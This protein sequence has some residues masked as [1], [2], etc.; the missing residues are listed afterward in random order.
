MDAR[1]HTY[2]YKYIVL[3]TY[4]IDTPDILIDRGFQD[5]GT[6]IKEKVIKK[7]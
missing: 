4:K 7:L 5:V 3:Y 2:M 6:I 1:T